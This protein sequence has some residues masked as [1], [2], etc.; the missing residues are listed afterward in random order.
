MQDMNWDDM[1]IF[2]AV[3]R[4]AQIARAAKTL[5]I[6]ATTV[7]RRL[8]R[9]EH[10]LGEV[11]FEQHHEG[12]RLTE[13]GA[14]LSVMA[15][16]MERQMSGFPLGQETSKSLSGLVRI[17]V[18]EG[19]GTWFI[20]TNLD[21]LAAT[22]PDL[23]IDL[24]ASSGFLSPSK[25]ETDVAILL[26]RP[27]KGPLVTRKLTDYGLRVYASH[28]YLARQVPLVE[29]VDLVNHKLI[30]YIPDFIYAPELRYLEDIAPALE[31]R[32]RSSSINAQHHLIASGSGIGVLPCF[33]GDADTSLSRVLPKIHLKRSFW[34]VTH[35]DTRNI[36]R[37]RH[38]VD[39]LIDLTVKKHHLL[40]GQSDGAVRPY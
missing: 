34:I 24:V 30:G 39:W 8:R 19:F 4:S 14:R 11:L 18:A 22:H 36:P 29:P 7:G 26:A 12:Q 9:L 1:R 35:R 15:E 25:R 5:K 32:L 20:A 3:A 21:S 6:D 37:V 2:L 10:T 31:P 13:A 23:S 33:I 17:S 40:L 16:E 38:F 27:R 28:E